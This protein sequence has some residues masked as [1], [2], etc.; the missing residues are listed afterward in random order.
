MIKTFYNH[1]QIMEN[2]IEQ[3]HSKSPLKPKLLLKYLKR[4]KIYEEFLEIEPFKP[5][6]KKD[7]LIAHT[8]EYV[9]AVY[10]GIK[11]LCESS[12]LPWSKELV[13]SLEYTNA[14]LY[15]AMHYASQNPSY[16]TFSPSAGF[17]HAVPENG[18]GFC[19]FSG[20]VIA[21]VKLYREFGTRTAWLDLDGHFGNSIESSREFVP[22]LNLAVPKGFNMNP[23]GKHHNYIKSLKH[24]LEKLEKAILNNEIDCV[25]WAHGADSHEDDDMGGYCTTEEWIECS[26]LF[27]SWVK[28]LNIKRKKPLPVT[29]T[30][31]GGYRMDDYY[32]V[33]S[34]HAADIVECLNILCSQKIDYTPE[35]RYNEWRRGF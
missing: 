10:K 19:S 6:T 8:K 7:F 17:H 11:P 14:S 16:I 34:L 33:L 25:V 29:L 32:S 27:F 24:Y 26:T 15:N 4:Q 28:Q 1:K 9:E 12:W 21:S 23:T 22:D 20:Q 5:F 31:F 35:V 30:L 2:N 3:S 18:T 13:T